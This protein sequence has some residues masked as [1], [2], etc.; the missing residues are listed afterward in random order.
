MTK[1]EER[2]LKVNEAE[3][4]WAHRVSPG[5]RY[6]S[7]WKAL[8]EEL[9][10]EPRLLQGEGPH[11]LPRPFAV[12]LFRIPGG[13]RRCPLHAHSAQWEYYIFLSGRGRIVLEGGDGIEVG[14]GDHVL[15]PPGWAHTVENTGQEDL[16][17]YVIA[18]NPQGESVYYPDSDKWLLYPPR[19]VFRMVEVDYYDGEE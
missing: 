2:L 15:Q 11:P 4:R 5:G 18:D 12:D 14:P 13:K 1:D 3:E 9:Q 19:K 16:T 10:A 8:S 7:Y 6:E 17:Y